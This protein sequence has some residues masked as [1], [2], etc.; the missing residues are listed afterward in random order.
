[1]LQKER[2]QKERSDLQCLKQGKKIVIANAW[3]KAR[4]R[5]ADALGRIRRDVIA[6][7]WTETES[8][9]GRA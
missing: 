7:A 4:K 9:R 3:G 6:N 5:I 8:K 1:M 2:V